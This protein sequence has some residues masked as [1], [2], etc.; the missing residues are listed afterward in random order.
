MILYSQEVED[1]GR[2]VRA[3]REACLASSYAELPNRRRHVQHLTQ[4]DLADILNVST[5]V[6]SQIEQG[7]Y[8]N[9][10]ASLLNRIGNALHFTPQQSFYVLGLLVERPKEQRSL[11][12]APE[13]VH[14]SIKAIAH[15]VVVTN[16]AFDMMSINDKAR[17]LFRS[18]NPGFAPKRNGATSIFQL[19][20]VREFIVDWEPYAAS[21]VSGLR[22]NYAGYP[23]YRDYIDA[24]VRRLESADSLFNT[25]WNLPDPLVKPTI[26]KQFRHPDLGLLN[27]RQILTEILE[28]PWLTRIEFIAADEETRQRFQH[29]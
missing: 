20:T 26:E 2:F 23:D 18:M 17:A 7:R 22:M 14:T 13:W 5:A 12:P 11:Q 1:I 8:P 9:L 24:L 3:R 21:L 29:M 4:G 16:P 28:A 19:A 27:V 25:F 10:S 15:P 6:I